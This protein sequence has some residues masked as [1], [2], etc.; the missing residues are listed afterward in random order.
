MCEIAYTLLCKPQQL[1]ACSVTVPVAM[2]HQCCLRVY[3]IIGDAQHLQCGAI[4]EQFM[5]DGLFNKLLK[6]ECQGVVV[7]VEVVRIGDVVV[8]SVCF[9]SLCVRGGGDG[10]WNGGMMGCGTTFT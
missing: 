9:G 7:G 2:A 6:W 3:G 4:M 8:T 10:M 5:D 1:L